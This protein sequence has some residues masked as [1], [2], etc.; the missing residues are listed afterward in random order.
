MKLNTD[1]N[2]LRDMAERE[3]NGCV[4]VG[5]LIGR[6]EQQSAGSEPVTLDWLRTLPGVEAA[7]RAELYS[8]V[9]FR[10]EFVDLLFSEDDGVVRGWAATRNGYRELRCRIT[11]PN[12]L[13]MLA[14]F[15][16]PVPAGEEPTT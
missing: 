4:S 13:V 15:G 11:Q 10:N 7:D 16:P 9:V 5:G 8:P 2:W 1:P 14:A 3:A 6:I 12:V